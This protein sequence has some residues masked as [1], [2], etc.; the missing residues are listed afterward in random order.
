[1]SPTVNEATTEFLSA[2]NV[3]QLS[4]GAGMVLVVLVM[5][6]L[7]GKELL[8]AAQVERLRERLRPLDVAIA[9][10]LVRVVPIVVARFWTAM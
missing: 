3:D 9:P 10:L 4:T 6:L 5:A 1:M 2:R 8:R 7:V